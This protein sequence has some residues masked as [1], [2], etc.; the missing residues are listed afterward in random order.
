MSI[1]L[2][3]D[4]VTKPTPRMR[5]AMAEAEVGN[6]SWGEDPTI[7]ELERRTAERLGK[8]AAMFVV[9]G[10]MGNQTALRVWTSRK[11][12]PEV[13]C[14]ERSHIVLNEAAGLATL[15]HAQART[16]PGRGGRMSL[17][18]IRA[19]VQPKG[20]VK[21]ET[22]LLALENTHN[23]ENGAVLDLAYMK[24]AHAL[25][26]EIGIPLHLDGARIWNAAVALGCSVADIA[27]HTDSVQLCFSKGL[28]CP[29]GSMVVG[30]ADFIQEAR[31]VRQY[32]G[33]GLRQAGVVA[34]ACLVALET[35]TERLHED[36]DNCRLLWRGL[37]GAPLEMIEPE[38][39]ILVIRS[40][41]RS[42]KDII[43]ACAKEGV[44]FSWISEH[45]LR[46]VT[47]ADVTRADCER[48]ASVLRAAVG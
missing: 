26:R 8:P 39:N 37:Q 14:H 10:T 25:A 40:A 5:K 7:N 45:E 32:M 29:M 12:A 4:T 28:S 48:A 33:G 46:A 30:P 35:M 16:L 21:P 42:A 23:Y 27:A 43:A 13:I 24:A 18:A 20:P 2:R 44:L 11:M 15:C 22:A 36:H 31:K 47:H 1:D 38:T 34:A 9:S 6:A 17:D 41:P 3:S 19:A